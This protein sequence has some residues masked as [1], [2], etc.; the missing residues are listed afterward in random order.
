MLAKAPGVGY[1]HEPFNPLTDPGIAGRPFTHF[2]AYVT[3]RDEQRVSARLERSLAFRYDWR[4]QAA[5]VRSP[6]AAARTVVTGSA[7]A[8]WR[9]QRARPLVKDPIAV[10]SAPWLADRF[11]MQVVVTV[12][13]PGA[14]VAS[15]KRL[16]WRHDFAALLADQSLMADRLGGYEEDVRRM[17]TS[18]GSPV[19]EAAL[20]WRLVYGT[21]RTYRIERPEWIV[22]RQE[23]LARE[24]VQ[25]FGELYGSLG[26]PFAPEARAAIEAHSSSENPDRLARTHGTRL[27]SA[28]S[29]AGWRSVLSPQE[30]SA[31]RAAVA[32]V[33][34][35]FYAEGEW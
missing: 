12:R 22:V 24:P 14:F 30:T 5:V 10:F 1:I 11:G 7:F 21:V 23:D 15:F 17:A 9:L 35:H 19:E 34:P 33:A 13:N 29:L 25:G 26:L 8:R 18:G 3:P 27:D 16:G 2:L 6:R 4:R 20:L 31:V 28:A 32:D